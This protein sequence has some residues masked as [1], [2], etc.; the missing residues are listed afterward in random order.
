[1][2]KFVLESPSRTI[3]RTIPDPDPIAS[4]TGGG[5]PGHSR[6]LDPMGWSFAKNRL[7]AS[8]ELFRH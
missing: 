7:K 1:M 5:E 6:H 2:S 4:D 3:R 8:A